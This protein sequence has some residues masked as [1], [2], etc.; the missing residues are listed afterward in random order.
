MPEL[1]PEVFVTD[2][3]S[4]KNSLIVVSNRLPF[5][6]KTNPETKALERKPSAGGLVTAVCPVVI[7]GKGLWVGWS[8]LHMKDDDLVIPES[9]PNDHT[10][11]AGLK[12]SQ[13]S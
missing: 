8:G 9:D 11:T 10:P 3:A 2:T 12:S 1:S 6:L 13:V 5:V 4:T 7:N